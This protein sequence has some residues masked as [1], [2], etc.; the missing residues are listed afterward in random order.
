M[1]NPNTYE[2]H[3]SELY[4]YSPENST[5]RPH[6]IVKQPFRVN[7]QQY[8]LSNGN[9]PKLMPIYHTGID[10]IKNANSIFNVRFNGMEIEIVSVKV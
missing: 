8:P 1:D 3:A 10:L 9:L 7:R 2:L 6:I 5:I 4:E